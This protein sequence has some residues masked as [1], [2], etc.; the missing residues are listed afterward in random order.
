MKTKTE[1]N[2]LVAFTLNIFFSIVEFVGGTLTG[3]V[4][5]LSDSFHDFGDA[6]SI[7]IS[8]FLELKSKK[9]PDKEHTYG[10]KRYSVLGSVISTTILLVGATFV[11]IEAIK[12]IINPTQIDYNGMMIFALYGVIIN[13]FATYFTSGGASL[14]QKAVNLHMLED[15]LGWLVILV[16]SILMKITNISIIDPILSIG[17]F[18]FIL[19][20]A[21]KNLKASLNIFLEKTPEHIDITVIKKELKNINGVIDIHQVHVSSMDGINSYITMHVVVKKYN[22]DI[23][24]EI[25]TKLKEYKITN[26]TLELELV[27]EECNY[28][29]SRL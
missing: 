15:V 9:R 23:K 29:N 11:I 28:K 24:K 25:R 19:V 21:I 5:I 18:I 27:D 17:V 20:Q 1:K 13:A 7:G 26:S 4:A 8:Y 3:S 14:N 2:I 10:Y 12:R 16:G 22:D 6:I